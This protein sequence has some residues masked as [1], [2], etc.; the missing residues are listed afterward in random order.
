[1]DNNSS[2][3]IA[4]TQSATS[5]E[6]DVTSRANQDSVR[7]FGPDFW[8]TILREDVPDRK[9]MSTLISS[10]DVFSDMKP[11]NLGDLSFRV[12][13]WYTKTILPKKLSLCEK[14]EKLFHLYSYL[15]KRAETVAGR[16]SLVLTDRDEIWKVT[17]TSRE[18]SMPIDLK[19]G[20]I[21]SGMLTTEYLKHF[22]E[23]HFDE[24]DEEG[25]IVDIAS[26]VRTSTSVLPGSLTYF[27]WEIKDLVPWPLWNSIRG[28]GFVEGIPTLQ[29]GPTIR[30]RE[31]E[32]SYYGIYLVRAPRH[33]DGFSNRSESLKNLIFR[34]PFSPLATRFLELFLNQLVQ[35][36]PLGIERVVF[37]HH[38]SPLVGQV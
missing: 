27:S 10:F 6:V 4:N 29:F 21:A 9:S 5:A 30:E 38:E 36:L 32:N 3:P 8:E 7:V 25:R 1:M 24:K 35:L 14:V 16:P 19:E 37:Q 17:S 33:P 20:V 12:F 34:V 22:C 13:E 18:L 2:S 28:L 15:E 23:I 31:N 11:D 26:E